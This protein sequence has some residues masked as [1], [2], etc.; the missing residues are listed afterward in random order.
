MHSG[1]LN[2]R[3][4]GVIELCESWDIQIWLVSTG[5]EELPVWLISSG[6]AAILS[7]IIPLINI[8]IL[9]QF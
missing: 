9:S 6:G 5:E 2:E 4:L 3:R 7:L 1:N 8:Q